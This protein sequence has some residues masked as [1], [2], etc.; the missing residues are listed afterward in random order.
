M[1]GGQRAGRGKKI[2][3][4]GHAVAH[5]KVGNGGDGKVAED[6][7]QGVHLVFLAHG[8]Q[9]QKGKTG[10]HGQNHDGAEQQEQH[11]GSIGGKRSH[12]WLSLYWCVFEMDA[13]KA[14][15]VPM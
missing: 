1:V 14:N 4:I 6:F 15:I 9:L 5:G 3:T 8:A 7:G 11:V 13:P 12:G 2:H 10:M